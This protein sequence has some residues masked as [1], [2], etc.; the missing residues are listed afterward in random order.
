MVNVT[1]SL[2]SLSFQE[3][4]VLYVFLFQVLCLLLLA[5]N[6]TVLKKLLNRYRHLLSGDRPQNLEE[7]LLTLGERIN[8]IETE[9][10]AVEE[11][12][13]KMEEESINYIQRWALHRYQ[14]F[15]NTG[16]DQS[17]SFVL[18]D[19]KGDGVL[20]SS[21]FGREESRTYAKSIQGGKANYPLSDEEHE[22]LV[23]AIQKK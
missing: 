13:A 8:K 6:G 1:S 9:L 18:L 7:L 2:S 15:A 3:K 22:V 19:K 11:R 23:K 12:V 14:A 10:K 17:F 4:L 16:G 20:V 5:I 21:I